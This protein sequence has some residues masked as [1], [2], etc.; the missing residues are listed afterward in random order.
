MYARSRS[1]AQIDPSGLFNDN[2]LAPPGR[3]HFMDPPEFKNREDAKLAAVCLGAAVLI[4][5]IIWVLPEIW[6]VMPYPVA[7]EPVID[8]SVPRPVWPTNPAPPVQ[9]SPPIEP[10][11]PYFDP[12]KF[13][14]WP[15]G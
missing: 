8:P 14:N 12:S 1:T 13:K 5:I 3:G 9:P 4:D 10:G 2:S 7:P 11:P 15:M 6:P